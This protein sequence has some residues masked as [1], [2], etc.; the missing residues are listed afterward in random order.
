M[1]LLGEIGLAVLGFILTALGTI[2]VTCF[3][4]M[5]GNLEKISNSVV[6]MNI[7]LERVILDQAWHKDEIAEIK[8]RIDNLED[9]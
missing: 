2:L 7:K 4:S 3:N 6:E 8:K 5:R 1:S 9:E